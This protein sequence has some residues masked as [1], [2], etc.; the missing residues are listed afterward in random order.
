MAQQLIKGATAWGLWTEICLI[1]WKRRKVTD[2]VAGT[3]LEKD[4]KFQGHPL[5]SKVIYRLKNARKL[6]IGLPLTS[7]ETPE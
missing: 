5:S 6:K 1:F 3:Y 2:F 7:N 4:F